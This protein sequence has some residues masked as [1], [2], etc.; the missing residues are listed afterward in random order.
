MS[1]HISV[2]DAWVR[3]LSRKWHHLIYF[4]VE[5]SRKPLGTPFATLRKPFADPFSRPS[6][7]SGVGG[8]QS[9]ILFLALS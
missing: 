8:K 4:Y 1:D 5:P 9:A 7:F 3:L 6:I 2:I